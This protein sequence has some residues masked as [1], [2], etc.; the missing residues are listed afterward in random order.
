VTYAYLYE[1]IGEEIH[2]W[3]GTEPSGMLFNA[4][5]LDANNRPHNPMI[6]A[7]AIM[8]CAL[9]VKHDK[10]IEDIVNFLSHCTSN[11]NI[12]VDYDLA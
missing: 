8:I 1:I 9:L 3:V 2:K 11:Y 10:K 5:V 6:N 12:E 4:P 7:G